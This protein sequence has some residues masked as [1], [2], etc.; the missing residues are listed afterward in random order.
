MRHR[1]EPESSS[2]HGPSRLRW[3]LACYFALMLGLFIG[4]S[5]AF[6]LTAALW[7]FGVVYLLCTGAVIVYLLRGG[8]DAEMDEEESAR[9]QDESETGRE[10]SGSTMHRSPR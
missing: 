4:L 10:P 5:T 8:P 6:S 9:R 2:F 1:H 7:I 3:V